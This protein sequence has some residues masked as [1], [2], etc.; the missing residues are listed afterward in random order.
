MELK[1]NSIYLKG[2]KEEK[3]R[4]TIKII[5]N[6]LKQNLS[7]EIIASIAGISIEEVKQCIKENQLN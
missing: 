3:E 7:L 5:S 4:W 6:G 1:Y 2:K